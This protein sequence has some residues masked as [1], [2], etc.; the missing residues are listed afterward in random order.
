MKTVSLYFRFSEIHSSSDSFLLDT[1]FGFT[2]ARF[3]PGRGLIILDDVE[4][5]GTEQ[6]ILSCGHSGLFQHNCHHFQDA[7]VS[8]QGTVFFC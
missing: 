3:G 2:D 8:C 6:N 5:A 4:C 1:V 7:S